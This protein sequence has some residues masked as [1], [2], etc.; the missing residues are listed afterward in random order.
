[1]PS[2]KIAS[3]QNP[4]Y[5]GHMKFL[6]K[7]LFN[8]PKNVAVFTT[9]SIANRIL[10]IL[11]VSHDEDDG[12]WQFLDGISTN[13]YSNAVVLGLQEVIELD[14]SIID[15]A[16]L[17]LGWSATRADKNAPWIRQKNIISE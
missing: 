3:K 9:V 1:L 17:P 16:D 11:K 10:P 8:E 15:L 4:Y 2:L 13:S 7:W 6:R 12:A 5:G 14:S